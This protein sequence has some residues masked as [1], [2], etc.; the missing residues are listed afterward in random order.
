MKNLVG[1]IHK[2]LGKKIILFNFETAQPIRSLKNHL[3]VRR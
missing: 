1:V 3:E 2:Y